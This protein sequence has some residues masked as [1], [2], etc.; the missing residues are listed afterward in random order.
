M[1]H[2]IV[3]RVAVI[4][5]IGCQRA[6]RAIDLSRQVRKYRDVSNIIRGQ[7]HRDDLMGLGIDREVK[8]SPPAA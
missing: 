5:S 2:P 6:D 8:F 3:N 1:Q 7:F 4:S